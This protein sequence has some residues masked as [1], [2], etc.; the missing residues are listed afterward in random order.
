MI[1]FL[2]SLYTLV[3]VTIVVCLTT[4]IRR[5]EKRLENESRLEHQYRRNED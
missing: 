5:L 4:D 2:L 1:W 3:W